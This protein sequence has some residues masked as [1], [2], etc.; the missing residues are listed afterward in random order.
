MLFRSV[1]KNGDPRD[2]V[3][4]VKEVA[5]GEVWLPPDLARKLAFAGAEGANPLSRLTP[6][7]MEI[8]RLVAR[9]ANLSQVAHA[10]GVSYKTVANAC[11]LI[12]TKL[13]ARTTADLVRIGV[14]QGLA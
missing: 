7:E 10:I 5:R 12:K 2:F 6:R 3:E 1:T 13:G 4:A 9:G 14:E 11:A 8:M